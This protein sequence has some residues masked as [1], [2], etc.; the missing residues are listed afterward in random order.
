MRNI[1]VTVIDNKTIS[2]DGE[3]YYAWGPGWDYP[4]VCFDMIKIRFYV[5][6]KISW[7]NEYKCVKIPLNFIKTTNINFG[8]L[9]G[10]SHS[11]PL[12][13]LKKD[14]EFLKKIHSR[15]CEQS[16]RGPTSAPSAFSINSNS[17][18]PKVVKTKNFYY[19]FDEET[20]KQYAQHG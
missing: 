1:E 2:I 13:F 15:Y 8:D 9:G 6:D 10:Y 17:K 16:S 7:N 19:Y 14:L 20:F 4:Y 3:L 5:G 12:F 11:V 18:M